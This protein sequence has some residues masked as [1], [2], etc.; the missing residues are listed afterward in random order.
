MIRPWPCTSGSSCNS[1]NAES[2]GKSDQQP[3][4]QFRQQTLRIAESAVFSFQCPELYFEG[5]ARIDSA[6]LFVAASYEQKFAQTSYFNNTF[7]SLTT[8]VI[9][10]GVEKTDS[11]LFK[12]NFPQSFPRNENHCECRFHPWHGLHGFRS[13][14]LTQTCFACPRAGFFQTQTSS[15]RMR[16]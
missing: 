11:A 9:R 16:R 2:I 12:E 6:R 1:L 13:P 15:S 5:K 4:R 10:Q 8:E 7:S 3:P 14:H